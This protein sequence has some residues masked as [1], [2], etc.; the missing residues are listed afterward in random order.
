MPLPRQGANHV[1]CNIQHP[2]CNTPRGMCLWRGR[3]MQLFIWHND[4]GALGALRR[5]QVCSVPKRRARQLPTLSTHPS[6]RGSRSLPAA[7][8]AVCRTVQAARRCTP[9]CCSAS[10]PC[11]C[12]TRCACAIGC[13]SVRSSCR[14]ECATSASRGWLRW[15]DDRRS[16]RQLG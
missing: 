15:K 12:H 7:H 4:Q 6:C 10:R 9:G 16:V 5:R 3:Q 11:D 1:P 14:Y 8:L 2:S 13:M